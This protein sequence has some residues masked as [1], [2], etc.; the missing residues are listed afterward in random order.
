MIP[1]TVRKRNFQLGLMQLLAR[2][3]DNGYIG[4]LKDVLV[5]D[6]SSTILVEIP[7][8]RDPQVVRT[9]RAAM[10][11]AANSDRIRFAVCLQDDDPDRLEALEHMP[12][13]RLRYFREADAPGTC[14]ARYACQELYGGE[15][16]VLHADAHMRFARFW[17][18]AIICQA[19]QREP[20]VPK[21]GRYHVHEDGADRR[22]DVNGT[23]L[24]HDG[25][26]PPR[27]CRRAG[28]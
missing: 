25:T 3:P 19:V 16:F 20:S 21:G 22:E 15:D 7:S 12:Y 27:R 18:V 23:P 8:Y 9:I 26:G 4:Y 11:Q 24:C 2:L 28:V 14:A 13:V 6:L 10:D 17:D 5:P 1:L